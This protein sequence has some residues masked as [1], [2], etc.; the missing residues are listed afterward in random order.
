MPDTVWGI[1][2][3]FSH[4]SISETFIESVLYARP[5]PGIY[6]AQHII[7]LMLLHLLPNP[8]LT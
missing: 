1:S 5:E 4:G 2:S 8:A 3:A 7:S 6:T